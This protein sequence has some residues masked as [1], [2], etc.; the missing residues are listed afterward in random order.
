MAI[1]LYSIVCIISEYVYIKQF[2]YFLF[3]AQLL[4]AFEEKCF[5][6]PNLSS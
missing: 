2:H 3:K 6:I 4:G 5:E 1:C